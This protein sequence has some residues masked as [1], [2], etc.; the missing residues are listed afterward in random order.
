MEVSMAGVPSSDLWQ[1]ARLAMVATQLRQRGIRDERVLS[2]M[3][4][5]PRHLF[6]PAEKLEHAYE[7]Q[8]IVIEAEQTISQPYI[9]AAMLEAVHLRPQDI[10]LEVGTG[11]G[12]QTALLA[13]LAAHVY[14]IER[15]AFLAN[16]AEQRLKNLRY[17]NT[18]VVVG[19]GTLGLPQH[20]PYDV[21]V[22]A[23]AA[24]RVPPALVQQLREADSPGDGGRLIVPVGSSENQQL[25][26][27][28]RCK[29]ELVTSF[30]D[31]CRFVPLIG[32][33]GFPA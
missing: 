5:V 4:R 30:L 20:A 31:G 7:D 12:Y 29:G 16:L 28:H 3:E 32:E 1:L 24:P 23:A 22:V 33:D 21:I 26:L 6:V 10:V 13:E 18:E 25:Q 14:S 17:N 27:V 15:Y 2:A 19:D 8:P 9:V 11:S